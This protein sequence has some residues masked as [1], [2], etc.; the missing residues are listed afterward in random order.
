[1]LKFPG[2]PPIHPKPGL[3]PA[4]PRPTPGLPLEKYV[5]NRYYL[6][7]RPFCRVLGASPVSIHIAVSIHAVCK[8]RFF[9]F[10]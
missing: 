3:P 6:V 8:A 4:N 7:V 5:R 9:V 2:K 10:F 1:L